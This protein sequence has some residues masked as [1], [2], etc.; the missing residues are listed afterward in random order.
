M[1][2]K[3][4]KPQGKFYEDADTIC[5]LFNIKTHP[6]LR[7]PAHPENEEQKE[8]TTVNFNKHR[9]DKNSMKVLFY[10]LPASPNVHTLKFTNN[11]LTQRQM[12]LLTDYMA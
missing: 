1:D 9:I 10:T 3:A 6:A 4:F 11:G 2:L 12:S 7:A 5:K 8:V